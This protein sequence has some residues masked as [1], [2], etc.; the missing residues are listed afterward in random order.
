MA[1]LAWAVSLTEENLSAVLSEAGQKLDRELI[2]KW[3]AAHGEGYFLRDESSA[4]DC[5]LFTPLV[6]SLMYDFRYPDN[7]TLFREVVKII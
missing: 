1:N 7:G 6:L 2:E 3:L 5:E 4:L